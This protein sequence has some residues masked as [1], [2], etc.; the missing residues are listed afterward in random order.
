V[1][2]ERISGPTI[3]AIMISAR[4]SIADGL[5]Q[6]KPI[7]VQPVFLAYSMPPRT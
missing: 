7:V 1:L 4:V 2:P 6:A 3:G 5:L